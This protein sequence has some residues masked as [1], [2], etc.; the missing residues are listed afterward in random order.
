[1]SGKR[2]SILEVVLGFVCVTVANK[3]FL[4]TIVF[5]ATTA[6]YQWVHGRKAFGDAMTV[7][8]I[9]TVLSFAYGMCT[10]SRKCV[11]GDEII[12]LD[13][14]SLT[15]RTMRTINDYNTLK[16]RYARRRDEKSFDELEAF[17]VNNP[18]LLDVEEDLSPPVE[19]VD[20]VLRNSLTVKGF[21]K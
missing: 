12:D 15:A 5:A 10:F 18:W 4:I 3:A 19:D 1:M 21:L 16:T 11:V 13:D 6:F 17:V 8:A 14:N 20:T 9:G 7:L 2:S